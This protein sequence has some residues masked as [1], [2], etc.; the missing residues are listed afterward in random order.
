MAS[1]PKASHAPAHTYFVPDESAGLA[2]ARVRDGE[3]LLCGS[4]CSHHLL[5]TIAVLY[6][7]SL[8]V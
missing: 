5:S 8:R 6:F 7:P 4:L 3:E 2:D 1:G